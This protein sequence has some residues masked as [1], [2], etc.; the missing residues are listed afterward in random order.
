MMLPRYVTAWLKRAKLPSSAMGVAESVSA[1]SEAEPDAV[2]VEF[3]IWV[4]IAK[5]RTEPLETIPDVTAEGEG[6]AELAAAAEVAVD[7]VSAT[8][9]LVVGAT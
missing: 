6:S 5:G 8:A 4:V 1:G 2:A 3:E 9:V 7:E